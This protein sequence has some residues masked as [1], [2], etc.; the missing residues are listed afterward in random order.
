M[1]IYPCFRLSP[2]V[3]VDFVAP[4][5][6]QFS[7]PNMSSHICTGDV[8]LSLVIL[9]FEPVMGI[10][11]IFLHKSFEGSNLEMMKTVLVRTID[12]RIYKQK[13]SWLAMGK[14]V[15][16]LAL[17]HFHPAAEGGAGLRPQP[18]VRQQHALERQRLVGERRPAAAAGPAARP[19][20][21]R[22]RQPTVGERRHLRHTHT[23]NPIWMQRH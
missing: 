4:S 15:A 7:M 6:T 19:H 14:S 17:T 5:T 9:V 12:M 18:V 23:T 20:A 16:R 1:F 13:N 2:A 8:L 3:Q 10:L 21:H 22:V 11:Y